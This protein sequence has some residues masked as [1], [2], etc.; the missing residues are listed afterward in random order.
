M[1]PMGGAFASETN[2]YGGNYGQDLWSSTDEYSG[3]GG[4]MGGGMGSDGL[5]SSSSSSM[6]MN[7]S[8]HGGGMPGMNGM[9][10]FNL[11]QARLDAFDSLEM[12]PMVTDANLYIKVGSAIRPRRPPPRRSHTPS[13]RPARL[14][15]STTTCRMTCFTQSS[16]AA[17]RS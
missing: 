9:S 17:A 11:D 7:G 14:R 16:P 3:L 10:Q 8:L 1:Y 15:T 6:A 2:D 13:H 12:N 4:A 5:S